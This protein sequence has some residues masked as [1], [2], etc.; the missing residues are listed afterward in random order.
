MNALKKKISEE[1]DDYSQTWLDA[2]GTGFEAL[3]S[4][5]FEAEGYETCVLSKKI[6]GS[7]E[8]DA[9]ILAIKT[10][11]LSPKFNEVIYIQAK[12]HNGVTGLWGLTQIQAFKDLI[13]KGSNNGIAT[14]RD[15][16]GN[17]V[18][19]ETENIKYVLI[20]SAKIDPRAYTEGETDS[21]ATKDE[22]ILIDGSDLSE[23]IIEYIDEIDNSL[24]CKLGLI[25]QF[26]HIDEYNDHN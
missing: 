15:I 7:G 5:L 14:V 2:K 3:I 26:V 20:S 25:K 1:L 18:Q 17:D 6:G 9:D 4:N 12:H 13:E 23:M 21:D 22:I 24:R 11:R 8:A 19:I 10:S 16:N